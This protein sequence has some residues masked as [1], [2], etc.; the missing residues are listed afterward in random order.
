M[1]AINLNKEQFE[2]LI[3]G[4]KPVI[5]DFW[6]PWCGYCR[7]IAPVY[8][9]IAEQYGEQLIVGKV[10][11]DEAPQ[12]AE[13]EKIE[14]IPTIVLYRNAEAIDSLVAPDSKAMIDRL[15]QGALEK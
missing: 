12:L 8:D 4:D 5:V 15:I 11:I 6:A 9:R 10:N 1:A 7:R 2:Q 3:H 13:A 14:V